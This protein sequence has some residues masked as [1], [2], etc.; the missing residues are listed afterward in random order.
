[1]KEWSLFAISF[2][3]VLVMLSTI[4]ENGIGIMISGF[5]LMAVGV[6]FVFKNRKGSK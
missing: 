2:G 3:G 1:M 5:L 4:Q 6:F